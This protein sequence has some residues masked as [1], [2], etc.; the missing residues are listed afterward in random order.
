MTPRE[1]LAALLAGAPIDHL[2]VDIGTTTLTG[3]RPTG[4]PQLGAA[5]G[6]ADDV[7][8]LPI[9]SGDE[10]ASLGTQTRRCGASYSGARLDDDE[11][12]TDR[13]GVRWIWA[14]GEPAPLDHPLSSADFRTI[15]AKPRRD[16]PNFVFPAD[17]EDPNRM[18]VLLADAPCAGL[19]DASFR[20][21][22]YFD[23]LEDTVDRWPA[24][25]A[26]FDWAMDAIIRDYEAMFANIAP[27]P[28]LVIYGDD[29]AYQTDLYLSEERFAFFLR[30]RMTRIFSVIRSLSSAQIVFHSCGAALPVLR[31][32][33][34]MGI[35]I[36]NFQPTAAGMSIRAVRRA[37]GPD[38]IFHGVLDFVALAA[39]LD[40]GDR[41][42]IER[43]LDDIAAGWPMIAAPDDNI[44]AGTDT[45]AIKRVASFLESLDLSALLRG[46]GSEA[47]ARAA[48]P[49]SVLA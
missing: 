41:R 2:L 9:L 18:Y 44:P 47:F 36:V 8:H 48:Y 35:R 30:P 12:F 20:L 37:L 43:A 14:N 13:D 19:L 1:R 15:L 34:A 42:G 4:A 21:R 25:N 39:A 22:G 17:A 38:I 7:M 5:T 49:A 27:R 32:V 33:T 26:I 28:D 29:L 31:E 11:V 16:P 23:L 10:L 24:A 45:R 3:L 6:Y 40:S 46:E